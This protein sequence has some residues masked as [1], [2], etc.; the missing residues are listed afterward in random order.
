MLGVD[1]ID[2]IDHNDYEDV[3]I[4]CGICGDI[5][6]ELHRKFDFILTEVYSTMCGI[7]PRLSAMFHVC[8]RLQGEWFMSKRQPRAAITKRHS[9][10]ADILII[11]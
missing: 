10:Q 8:F 7:R 1:Y 11:T 5:P 9:A 3:N 2:A 6:A 4:I